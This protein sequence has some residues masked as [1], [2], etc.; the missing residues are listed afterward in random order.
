MIPISL[1]F[2]GLLLVAAEPANLWGYVL[3]LSSV[4][5]WALHRVWKHRHEH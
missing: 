4:P 5:V 1:L 2:G 3:W